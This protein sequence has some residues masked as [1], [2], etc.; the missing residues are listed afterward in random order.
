MRYR[1]V[2]GSRAVVLAL[3]MLVGVTGLAACDPDEPEPASTTAPA[4]DTGASPAES[5]GVPPTE[6]TDIPP[7]EDTD[8]PPTGETRDQ[9]S[10]QPGGYVPSAPLPPTAT[11]DETTD[12]PF[13]PTEP[14]PEES[15]QPAPETT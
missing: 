1:I 5:T 12:P 4:E 15:S 13:E 10:T 11:E 8:V 7:A 2:C 9:P 3:L 14:V 6:D